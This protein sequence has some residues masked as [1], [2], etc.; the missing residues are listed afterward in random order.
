MEHNNITEVRFDYVEA[1]T[2]GG[3]PKDALRNH[4]PLHSEISLNG[5]PLNCDCHN[6][7]LIKYVRDELRP[8]IKVTFD[9]QMKDLTCSS[10]PELQNMSIETL[11]PQLLICPV[12]KGCPEECDCS[13][14]PFDESIIIDCS[15]K[16]LTDYPHIDFNEV[17]SFPLSQT[18]MHLEGNFLNVGPNK[19]LTGYDNIT[20]LYLSFN[21]IE[22][23][24]WLPP[25]LK[26]NVLFLYVSFLYN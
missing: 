20:R 12:K 15:Q 6:F 24:S 4:D 9:L 1:I 22:S 23:I 10:P 11:P 26:V 3:E 21:E 5:N 2:T 25:R 14:R 19:S 18:E 17:T 8:E 13:Q 16:N 7:D